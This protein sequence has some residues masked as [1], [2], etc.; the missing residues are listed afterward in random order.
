ML[1]VKISG[2]PVVSGDHHVL[3]LSVLQAGHHGG[4]EEVH[5]AAPEHADSAANLQLRLGLH[6]HVVN[7]SLQQILS[8]EDVRFVSPGFVHDD[9]V[10]VGRNNV[11][12]PAWVEDALKP[13]QN[14]GVT[15]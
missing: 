2:V 7:S 5:L 4:M 15:N 1:D 14:L 9:T 11:G 8:G 10:D 6:S 13:Q 3:L 12:H